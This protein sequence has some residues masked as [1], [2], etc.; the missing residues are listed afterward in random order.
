MQS[1]CC[2]GDKS[3]Y[4]NIANKANREQPIVIQ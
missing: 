3:N 2:L 4:K 1:K